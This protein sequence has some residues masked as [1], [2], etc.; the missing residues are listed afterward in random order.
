MKGFP[1]TLS[2]FWVGSSHVHVSYVLVPPSQLVDFNL[3]LS[4]ADPSIA[5]PISSSVEEEKCIGGAV[6]PFVP[7]WTVTESDGDGVGP[8]YGVVTNGGTEDGYVAVS[9]GVR[10]VGAGN[11]TCTLKIGQAEQSFNVSFQPLVD[12]VGFRWNVE[13]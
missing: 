6:G 5:E 12:T 2:N 7:H 4:C 1:L 9:S 3:R 11:T 8:S 13:C 10:G